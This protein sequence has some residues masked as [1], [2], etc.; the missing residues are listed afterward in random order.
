M[1]V[2]AAS[3]KGQAHFFVMLSCNRDANS[4]FDTLSRIEHH[5]IALQKSFRCIRIAEAAAICLVFHHVF[6]Q[7]AFFTSFSAGSA[8]TDVLAQQQFECRPTH[9]MDF[10]GFALND[11]AIFDRNGT[12][13]YE[14]S[15]QFDK[16]NE[17][18]SGRRTQIRQSAQSRN[19]NPCPMS[20]I[21]NHVAGLCESRMPVDYNLHGEIIPD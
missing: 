12:R 4:A 7:S 11:H 1:C 13:G 6:Q 14:F 20:G 15:I 2:K 5:L 8:M 21:D 19:V 16:A 17:A 9:S 3:Q 10:F 18:R